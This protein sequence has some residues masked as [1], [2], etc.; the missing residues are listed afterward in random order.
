MS[1][2]NFL[3][4]TRLCDRLRHN[5]GRYGHTLYFRCHIWPNAQAYDDIIEN[6]LKAIA[7]NR[8][9][10]AR[11]AGLRISALLFQEFRTREV[12]NQLLENG[13]T[14]YPVTYLQEGGFNGIQWNLRYRRHPGWV[15]SS[16]TVTRRGIY[17][18]QSHRVTPET[19]T[20]QVRDWFDGRCHNLHQ[21]ERNKLWNDFPGLKSLEF[22][23]LK[24]RRKWGRVLGKYLQKMTFKVH[25][26][27]YQQ[28]VLPGFGERPWF[29]LEWELIGVNEEDPTPYIELPGKLARRVDMKA[30]STLDARR[31]SCGCDYDDC[32]ICYPPEDE[33]GGDGDGSAGVEMAFA[34]ASFVEARKLA[35]AVAGYLPWDRIVEKD[36]R[37]GVHVHVD[38]GA[39]DLDVMNKLF[40]QVLLDQCIE[41][42]LFRKWSVRAPNEWCRPEVSNGHSCAV[43]VGA[44]EGKTVEFR[45]FASRGVYYWGARCIEATA[46]LVYWSKQTRSKNPTWKTFFKWAAQHKNTYNIF[47]SIA[48]RSLKEVL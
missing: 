25:K 17:R 26:M 29:G 13:W 4:H 8:R 9:R 42:R 22:K 20:P 47:G 37:A 41:A 3:G 31:S 39:V 45:S 24:M 27:G 5:A 33:E 19:W 30:D 6:K 28:T 18:K 40:T 43:H 15:Y 46:A 35:L 21:S 44:C 2:C 34:P 14:G 32:S 38:T 16:R 10:K 11:N 12:V 36:T 1:V 7:R 23:S 48:A